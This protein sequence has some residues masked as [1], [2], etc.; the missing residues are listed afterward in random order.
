MK[1]QKSVIIY[2]I[3]CWAC[4]EIV[5]I[6]KKKKHNFDVRDTNERK[7]TVPWF[8]KKTEVQLLWMKKFSTLK[9][10]PKKL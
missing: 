5:N 10:D 7:K 4:D 9:I 3:P 6:I 8:E 1:D 2:G